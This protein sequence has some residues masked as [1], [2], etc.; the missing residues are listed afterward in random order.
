M[1]MAAVALSHA[2]TRRT[3]A[4]CRR[5]LREPR[6]LSFPSTASRLQRLRQAF[7]LTPQAIALPLESRVLFT[8]SLTVPFDVFPLSTQLV[9]LATQTL[10]FLLEALTRRYPFAACGHALLMPESRA[11]YKRNPLTSYPRS[12]CHSARASA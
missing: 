7:D 8:Q 6:G 3:R 5:T 1:A 4:W 12:S 10:D 11:K 2:S 9:A